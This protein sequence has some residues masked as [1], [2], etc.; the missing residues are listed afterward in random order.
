MHG[1]RSRHEQHDSASRHHA[2]ITNVAVVDDPFHAVQGKSAAALSSQM[3]RSIAVPSA[4]ASA[5]ATVAAAASASTSKKS[6]PV[7]TRKRSAAPPLRQQQPAAA[8]L[9]A[10]KAANK[11]SSRAY[12]SVYLWQVAVTCLLVTLIAVVLVANRSFL[13]RST[14]R[15]GT[16]N[17]AKAS[18]DAPPDSEPSA[19]N[20]DGSVGGIDP[21]AF[22][23]YPSRRYYRLYDKT[24]DFLRHAEYIYGEWPALLPSTAMPPKLCVDQASWLPSGSV[25]SGGNGQKRMAHYPFADGTNPSLLSMERIRTARNPTKETSE[26]VKAAERLSKNNKKRI[27]YVATACMTN[28]QCVWGSPTPA[29]F[30]NETAPRV[31][32]TTLLLLDEHF[33]T[34]AQATL[35]LKRDGPW[36]KMPAPPKQQPQPVYHTPALDDARL[37]VHAGRIWVSY[38]EGRGF[39]YETQVLNPVRVSIDLQ[40]EPARALHAEIWASETTSFCCGRNM[41]LME[42]GSGN[43]TPA[44]PQL[45][46][47][48]WVDPVTVIEVDTTPHVVSSALSKKKKDRNGQAQRRKLQLQQQVTKPR[49]S[50]VHGT[51][52]FMVRLPHLDEFLGVAHFHRPHDRK[53]NAYAKFGHHYTHALF[54]VSASPPYELRRLSAEFVLPQAAKPAAVSSSTTSDAEE[55]AEI[56]QFASGLEVVD[57]NRIIIAYGINDCEAAIAE[58][59]LDE[60]MA[61]WLRPVKPGTQVVDVME[62]LKT[63]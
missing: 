23:S 16:G 50:H 59:S 51:N 48:T 42:G 47:L 57:G 39:G 24:P 25:V 36:G 53:P 62:P 15:N 11:P 60:A 43:A 54:T 27:Q 32:L 20:P 12:R 44:D 13:V 9:P 40:K 14:R 10:G 3:M 34:V 31:V 1:H 38:R 18:G 2:A 30:S 55:D 22:R 4:A 7:S 58:V 8:P 35:R 33:G 21:C 19:Q 17:R 41:A 56:I 49:K 6:F 61:H 46:S 37:F 29:T 28:S 45:L 5:A 63:T 52:A 26:F